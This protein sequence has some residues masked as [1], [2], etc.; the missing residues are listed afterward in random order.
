MSVTASA[1]GHAI[2]KM[3]GRK[4][5]LV[6]AHIPAQAGTLA[7]WIECAGDF[8]AD[9]K[10]GKVLNRSE[11]RSLLGGL[12]VKAAVQVAD[13]LVISPQARSLANSKR[14]L[15]DDFGSHIHFSETAQRQ[16]DTL[17]ANPTHA[18]A[19]KAVHKALGYLGEDTRH[20]SLNTHQ[21]HQMTGP[22]GER[23]FE[24]YAQN[25]TPGAHRIF[26]Y[27]GAHGKRIIHA[28]TPHP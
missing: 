25:H 24:A 22:Q 2:A 9:L 3:T 10:S 23:V 14:V 26:F 11:V 18:A 16:L 21:Y 5:R 1:L 13:A 20:A 28:I 19:Y 17:A 6:N 15:T 7:A 4:E 8:K 12:D 27:Y